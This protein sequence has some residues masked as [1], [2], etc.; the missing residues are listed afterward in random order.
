LFLTTVYPTTATGADGNN[1]D[2]SAGKDVFSR[3][4]RGKGAKRS[5]EHR[6]DV[7]WDRHKT[8]TFFTIPKTQKSLIF[9]YIST[10]KP[11]FFF[12]SRMNTN[13]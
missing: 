9:F 2:K 1:G 10:V 8:Y 4:K 13:L 3:G 12:L 5:G 11:Q 6:T 7:V